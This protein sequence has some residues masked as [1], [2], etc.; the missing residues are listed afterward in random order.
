M[1]KVFL[2]AVVSIIC[3][4][5]VNKASAQ[6]YNGYRDNRGREIRHDRMDIYHDRADVYFDQRRIEQKRLEMQRERYYGNYGAY[7]RDGRELQYMHRDENRD[8]RDIN[9]DRRDIRRDE[10]H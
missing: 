2:L 4:V 9:R 10:R 3:A 7:R 5:T 1:K 6:Y 8:R